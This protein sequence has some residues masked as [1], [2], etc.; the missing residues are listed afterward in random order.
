MFDM[1]ADKQKRQAEARRKEAK[2]RLLE[3]QQ[4][5]AKSAELQRERDDRELE[6][7]RELRRLE[8]RRD[9]EI[10]ETGGVKILRQG[11]HVIPDSRTDDKLVLPPSVFQ[12]LNNHRVFEQFEGQNMRGSVLTFEVTVSSASAAEPVIIEQVTTG[13]AGDVAGTSGATSTSTTVIATTH[14]GVAE[15]TADE[16]TVRFGPKVLFSLMAQCGNIKPERVNIR[17]KQLS[18]YNRCR[19]TFQPKGAG[20]FQQAESTSANSGELVGPQ[21]VNID[22]RSVLEAQLQFH[23]CLTENDVVPVRHENNTYYLQAKLLEP[24]DALLIL[25]TEME[26]DVLPSE[27]VEFEQKLLE[28]KRQKEERLK[29]MYDEEVER[30]RKFEEKDLAEMEELMKSAG[31]ASIS[32]SNLRPVEVQVRLPNGKA[33]SRTFFVAANASSSSAASN[34]TGASSAAAGAAGGAAAASGNCSTVTKESKLVDVFHWLSHTPAT[35][36][37]TYRCA[38]KHQL[39][40]SWPGHRLVLTYD[41]H[42]DKTLFEL[43]LRG[44]REQLFFKA[45]N[46]AAEEGTAPDTQPRAEP[47]DPASKLSPSSDHR[48][49]TQSKESNSM[50]V[51]APDLPRLP[52]DWRDAG[53]DAFARIDEQTPMVVD[54]TTPANGEGGQGR[55]GLDAAANGES[56]ETNKPEPLDSV[57]IFHMLRQA[58][59]QHTPEEDAAYAKKWGRELQQLAELGFG[60]EV[61]ITRCIPF[62]KKWNGTMPRV[63]NSLML[64]EEVPKIH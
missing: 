52:S 27:Q 28:R 7:A 57:T 37:Y 1:A 44:R 39:V 50:G 56:G 40:Q 9:A 48:L 33:I 63:V 47:H 24:D 17:Y 45:V 3:Q 29:A 23:T 22:L 49:R 2:R 41:D 59:G 5:A 6:K 64:E 34:S 26:I 21:V 51:S 38:Q 62:L 4:Q 18:R 16:N 8:E 46:D 53:T 20:F 35:M 32:A 61:W 54:S 30:R 58:P 36:E 25:N 15:F 19:C 14:C 13:A 12:E 43:G 10:F 42:R 11:L 60:P 31:S 55:S